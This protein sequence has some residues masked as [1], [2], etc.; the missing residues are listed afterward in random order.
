LSVNVF[1]REKD[2]TNPQFHAAAVSHN[3]TGVFGHFLA[4]PIVLLFILVYFAF[5]HSTKVIF[6][7]K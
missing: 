4:T 2:L 3:S 5:L 7:K 1:S 6:H